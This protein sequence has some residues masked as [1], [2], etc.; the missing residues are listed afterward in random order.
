MNSGENNRIIIIGGG[1]IGLLS[2]REL[3]RRGHQV[4]VV[5]GGDLHGSASTG[6]A[7]VIA[8]GHP[9]IPTPD[10]PRQ[11]LRLLMDRRSPLYIPPP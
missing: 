6:N 2:A 9:P 5:E 7:G 3:L 4:L 10:L 1:I 8:P 11:A